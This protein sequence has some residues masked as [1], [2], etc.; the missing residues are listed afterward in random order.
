MVTPRGPPLDPSKLLILVIFEP[1]WVYRAVGDILTSIVSN[2]HF[3]KRPA[4]RDMTICGSHFLPHVTNHASS[5]WWNFHN[6][7]PRPSAGLIF[8]FL[9]LPCGR[10]IRSWVHHLRRVAFLGRQTFYRY[11]SNVRVQ[12]GLARRPA[13]WQ[14]ITVTTSS[15]P[16]TNNVKN[17]LA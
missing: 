17:K 6:S 2:S 16:R 8:G 13:W 3:A 14:H 9:L 7:T 5:Y 4:A 11:I 12:F 1:L 15:V 10:E